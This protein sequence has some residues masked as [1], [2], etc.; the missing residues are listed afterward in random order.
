MAN[1]DQWPDQR[2]ALG[3][4]LPGDMKERE[5]HD[6]LQK[7]CDGYTELPLYCPHSIRNCSK[8]WTI[9]EEKS[10]NTMK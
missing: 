10:S 5:L 4:K 2:D 1:S 7:V 8:S 6:R 3:N 9:R